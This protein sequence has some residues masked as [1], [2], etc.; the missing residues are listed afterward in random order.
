[1][2]PQLLCMYKEEIT[3]SFL[4]AEKTLRFLNMIGLWA[5]LLLPRRL[6]IFSCLSLDLLLKWSSIIWLI[7]SYLARCK[8]FPLLPVVT[9][10]NIDL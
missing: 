8:L 10:S 5:P 7:Y 2:S 1:M 9:I 3:D 4:T 6:E